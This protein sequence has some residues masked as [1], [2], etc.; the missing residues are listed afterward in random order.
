MSDFDHFNFLKLL[1]VVF[2][3]THTRTKSLLCCNASLKPVLHLSAS[4]FVTGIFVIFF[5]SCLFTC[6]CYLQL[7]FIFSAFFFFH[8]NLYNFPHDGLSVT[9]RSPKWLL[10]A[11]LPL[12]LGDLTNCCSVG[13]WFVSDPEPCFEAGNR[14]PS[15]EHHCNFVLSRLHL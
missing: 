3:H 9:G 5:P 14:L 15:V 10:L 2:A 1:I 12:N 4:F 11:E 6:V 13:D 7:A 8:F